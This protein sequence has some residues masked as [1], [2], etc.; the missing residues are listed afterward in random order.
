MVSTPQISGL[1]SRLAA[2]AR[3]L[4]TRFR[5]GSVSAVPAAPGLLGARVQVPV[6]ARSPETDACTAL[7]AAHAR[8]A[9]AGR[10]SELL[11]D[12]RAADQARDRAP[13]GRPL[14]TVISEGAR[15]RLSEALTR[16]DWAAAEAEVSHLETVLAPHDGDYA[17]AHLIAQARID[18]G[19][20]RRSAETGPAIARG[21]WQAFLHQTAL[22]EAVLHRHD[23][24]EAGSPL[25]AATR[26]LLVRGLDEGDTLF[27]DWYEDWSDLDPGSAEAHLTHA[28]DL[29][30]QWF[31]TATRFDDEARAAQRR[32]ARATGAMAYAAFYMVAGD[33]SDRLP[34]RMDL[35]LFLA[36]LR[37]FHHQTGCQ[38]RA[39]IVAGTLTELLH[40][41]SMDADPASMR[42]AQVRQ[43]L[44]R[45]LRCHLRAFHLPAWD[46]GLNCIRFALEQVFAG[47]TARGERILVG[48]EGLVT[49]PMP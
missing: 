4:A 37:D 28:E 16:R 25:L 1:A 43:A 12:L 30:P 23:P 11:R 3:L 29:L 7:V 2:P 46:Q 35:S 38:H 41:Y 40:A 47:E 33:H 21:A 15:S 24:I 27:R 39:N 36:G 26:Y 45:H 10:W 5:G 32:T 18:L 19:W 48:P 44:S 8:T 20:A 14:A 42:A 6:L 9:A 22:A 34:A 49:A 13:D 17:A 31:G